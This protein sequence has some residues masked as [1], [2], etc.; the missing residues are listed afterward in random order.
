MDTPDA[1]SLKAAEVD[2]GKALALVAALR[3]SCVGLEGL[4]DSSALSS[5]RRTALDYYK[6]NM[7]DMAPGGLN[8]SDVTDSIG[9]DA[10]EALLPDLMEIFADEDVV[11]FEPMS[12][13]DATQARVETEFIRRVIFDDNPGWVE[14]YTAFKDALVLKTGVWKVWSD[15]REV[16]DEEE[17]EGVTEDALP[18]LA[19][20]AEQ[21]GY[22][23]EE[24]G[25]GRV[26]LVRRRMRVTPRFACVPPEDFGTSDDGPRLKDNDYCVE[27]TRPRIQDLRGRVD[28]DILDTLQPS[29]GDDQPIHDARDG[30]T[31]EDDTTPDG[32]GDMRRVEVFEHYVRTDLDGTGIHV[33]RVDTNRD[34]SVMLDARIVPAM[35]YAAI[36]PFINPH[37][38]IGE[39][40]MDKLIELQ[41]VRT[42]LTRILIDSG[43][44][45]L[46]QRV[47]I[48]EDGANEFTEDDYVANELGGIVRSK[49]GQA[50]NPIATGQ[51]GFDVL[52]ALEYAATQAEQRAGVGRQTQGLNS[53]AMHD[54]ASG[55][56]AM[57]TR[58]QRR[59]RLIARTFAETGFRDLCMLMH[60]IIRTTGTAPLT[61]RI[62]GRF[63]DLDPATMAER[64]DMTIVV[65]GGSREETLGLL[66]EIIQLMQVISGEQ[67][68]LN[69]PLLDIE[70]AHALLTRFTDTLGIKGLPTIWVD[71]A[72]QPDQPE[73]P[74][75]A[76]VEAQAEA[77]LER[78]KARD[79]AQ[80][81][82]ERMHMQM[83]NDRERAHL[84]AELAKY[85]AML[86]AAI[87]VERAAPQGG[88]PD[89]RPGGSLAA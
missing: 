87:N 52:S 6:G 27:R 41:R 48:G 20:E 13:E 14:L 81:E 57:L 65:G 46:N 9:A 84:E 58:S 74:D 34:E 50:V 15:Q 5:T 59:T 71:P 3:Q 83:E 4:T 43:N 61:K 68:G 36:T 86:E 28:D 64:E 35:P 16:V 51:L 32:L 82:R 88:L 38:F 60:D 54:T 11:A 56:K 75:P 53:D 10:I 42:N 77:E 22:E 21:Q 30:I 70:G 80:R 62:D 37:R 89:F 39:S 7:D 72:Q 78:A 47:E 79:E 1:P 63:V 23:M 25:A 17:L 55:Q 73:Q 12:D 69:G 66:R 24:A 26:R 40:M 2:S 67:G 29:R 8:R 76:L 49:T 19:M 45:A 85:K 31:D 44:L 18:A 33:W